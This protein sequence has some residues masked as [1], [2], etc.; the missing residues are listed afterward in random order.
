M[1][2]GSR[3]TRPP[4]SRIRPSRMCST[5]SDEVVSE[6]T[7]QRRLGVQA[8]VVNATGRSRSEAL[9]AATQSIQP[10]EPDQNAYIEPF[11]RSY[12]TEVLN[13]YGFKSIAQRP[14]ILSAGCRR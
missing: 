11:N 14:A 4:R 9:G 10:G 13:A 6:T 8:P 3:V 1:R 7:G 12:R 2:S 5:E